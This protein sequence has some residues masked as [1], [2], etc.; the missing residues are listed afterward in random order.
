MH[1]PRWGLNLKGIGRSPEEKV[2]NKKE[3]NANE[4]VSWSVLMES[5]SDE[6]HVD[7]K[8]LLFYWPNRDAGKDEQNIKQNG[9]FFKNC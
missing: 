2:R 9:I 7:R 6:A 4:A 8:S 1:Q 5:D 3:H